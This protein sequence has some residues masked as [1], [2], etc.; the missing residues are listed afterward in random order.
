MA[1]LAL[2]R[3]RGE[4]A[5]KGRMR[6]GASLHASRCPSSAC[7][8]HLP[9]NGE[10]SANAM[11]P[12]Q[13]VATLAFW[14]IVVAFAV[15]A[16][17]FVAWKMT[18]SV[19]LYSDALE[20]IVNVIAAA[21]AFWAITVSHKPADQDHP[22]GHHKAEY[23]S[24]VLEGV[25]IVRRGAADPDRGLARTGR[26]PPTLDQPWNG[27]AVNGVAALHQR[28]LGARADPHRPQPRNR[29][30]WSPTASHIMT[31]VVT[32]I[33]VHRRP[34]R[35][36]SLTGWHILDPL[37]A[38]LV[39]LN[40]LWQGWKVIGSSLD[41]LM[42]RAVDTRRAHAH[43]RHHLG[44]FQ[45]R[46]R[47]ARPQDAHRRPRHLHRVPSGRRCRHDASAKATSSATAS[48]RR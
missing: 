1:H 14:S 25:L 31:D 27:L 9:A 13:K 7:R 34:G 4:V 42:D 40:I 10:K 20:S 21:A 45:G 39:A 11:P 8:H 28:R 44:Q 37:L 32:S 43:P 35:R 24:A 29:R 16:L 22:F 17:K 46:D 47:G 26:S 38:V 6:G 48:R 12:K 18:G 19:A 3:S 41:G 2:P 5:A 23:F 36:R 30:R 33:G 15:L